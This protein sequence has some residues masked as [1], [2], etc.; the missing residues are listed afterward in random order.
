MNV[1]ERAIFFEIR[2][3]LHNMLNFKMG[4]KMNLEKD[5]K[6]AIKDFNEAIEQINLVNKRFPILSKPILSSNVAMTP[7]NIRELS[8]Y[9]HGCFLT[10][11]YDVEGD[12]YLNFYEN[13]QSF[14]E[15]LARIYSILEKIM[16]DFCLCEISE[17][18]SIIYSSQIKEDIKEKEL[19]N[20]LYKLMN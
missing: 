7:Y 16:D 9:V 14:K 8:G 1:L 10:K 15:K 19:F 13:N 3:F 20:L 18:S 11:Y 17:K 6:N 2:K 12:P 5:L 4:L